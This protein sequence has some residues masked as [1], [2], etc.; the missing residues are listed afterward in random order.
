MPVLVHAKRRV[1]AA[2][3]SKRSTPTLRKRR[4]APTSPRFS[5]RLLLNALVGWW[6][7]DP[8]AAL[9]MV[10]EGLER[11]RG[12]RCDDD[13][14]VDEVNTTANWIHCPQGETHA[15]ADHF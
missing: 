5:S 2:I 7:A 11:I 14:D 1:A 3:G 4:S 15:T 6:R 9:I 13:A 8:V 10:R 12:E